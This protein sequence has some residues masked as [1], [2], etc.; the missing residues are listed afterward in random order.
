[1]S[2]AVLNS[3]IFLKF[4]P[5]PPPL[6]TLTL[7]PTPLH[8]SWSCLHVFLDLFSWKKN[9]SRLNKTWFDLYQEKLLQCLISGEEG[10][11]IVVVF[12]SS[13]VPP[14][15]KIFFA[16]IQEL[17]WSCLPW[18]LVI[19]FPSTSAGDMSVAGSRFALHSYA[20]LR[21]CKYIFFHTKIHSVVEGSLPG[22]A[23]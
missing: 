7:P 9:R 11:F 4:T 21:S 13:N 19:A 3:L 18:F 10:G 6:P 16:C 20:C 23:R 5:P 1:M 22:R 17:H 12:V 8:T 15:P 14:L 2:L